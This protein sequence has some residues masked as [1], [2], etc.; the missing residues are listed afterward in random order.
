MIL[1]IV[2]WIL[3]GFSFFLL[4]TAWTSLSWSEV[5][6][7]TGAYALS[8]VAGLLA[9]FAP[10]GIGVREGLLG[11]LLRPLA[12]QGLPVNLAAVGSRLLSMIAELIVLVFAVALHW[13]NAKRSTSAET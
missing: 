9:V 1:F 13:S 7:L 4:A 3:Q 8:H 10:G 2:I 5:P 12:D 6:R 11:I